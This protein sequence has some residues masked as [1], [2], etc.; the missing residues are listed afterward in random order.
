MIL[1]RITRAV[2][3]QN[4]FAVA[5]E[6]VIVILGVVI[7]F[8]INGWAERRDENARA[9]LYL[10]RLLA[11]LEANEDRF[12]HAFEFRQEVPDL[13][14]Q[15]LSYASG[16]AEPPD[17]WRVIV[18][19]FNASQAGG[20]EMVDATYREMVATGDLRL[21]R[22]IELRGLLSGYYTASNFAQITNDLPDFREHVRGIIPIDLQGYIWENCWRTVDGLNQRLVDC[23]APA[24]AEPERLSAL[25]QALL[26]NTQLN[27]ELQYWVS[28][29]YAA[30]NIHRDRIQR[31]TAVVAAVRR[32]MELPE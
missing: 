2:R 8:Q 19:Y 24:T 7:G 31:T 1:S 20:A 30:L 21:L 15:A 32:A 6:F 14:L 10:D 25:V 28:N 26:Q 27:A 17:D 9:A 23:E 29:Q 16:A 13:G 22:G 4:W 18:T 3:E 11:D 5:I 12:S